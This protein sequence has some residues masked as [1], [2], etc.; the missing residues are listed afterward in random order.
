[1]KPKSV[2]PNCKTE[3]IHVKRTGSPF[4]YCEPCRKIRSQ[5]RRKV[6]N[7]KCINCGILYKKFMKSHYCGVCYK[8]YDKIRRNRNKKKIKKKEPVLPSVKLVLNYQTNEQQCAKKITAKEIKEATKAYLKKGKKI[9]RSEKMSI[10]LN[11]IR[12]DYDPF[13]DLADLD[14]VPDYTF[15]REHI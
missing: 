5:K 15:N 13:A 2:C 3:F 7:F 14:I 1:M 6:K 4:I 12:W 9:K 10:A 11:Y 8:N